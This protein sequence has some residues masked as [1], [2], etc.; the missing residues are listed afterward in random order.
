[1]TKAKELNVSLIF[2]C[3]P[4]A[5]PTSFWSLIFDRNMADYDRRQSGGYNN[6]KR[7]YRGE[8][9]CSLTFLHSKRTS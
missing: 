7:R 5:S 8:L 3:A 9:I 4:L 6:R 2:I 1:M